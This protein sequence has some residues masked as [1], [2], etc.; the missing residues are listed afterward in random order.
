MTYSI[1]KMKPSPM[2][3]TGEIVVDTTDR[4]PK[5]GPRKKLWIVESEWDP[6]KANSKLESERISKS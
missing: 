2:F 6:S 5:G 4:E 3:D 1:D